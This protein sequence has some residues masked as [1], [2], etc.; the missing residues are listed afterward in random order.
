MATVVKY[1]PNETHYILLGAGFGAYQSSEPDKL[2]G[3]LARKR[4][5]GQIHSAL[6][7]NAAGETTWVKS[8]DLVVISVDGQPPE[9]ILKRG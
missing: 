9:D 6:I 4:N 5:S 8:E 2:L 7:C 3:D 1:L